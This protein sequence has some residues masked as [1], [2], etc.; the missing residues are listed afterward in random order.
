MYCGQLAQTVQPNAKCAGCLH[1]NKDRG[2][3]GVCEI[4]TRPAVCGDGNSPVIGYAPV[5]RLTPEYPIVMAPV[6]QARSKDAPLFVV[7]VQ[8]LGEEHAQMVKSIEHELVSQVQSRCSLHQQMSKGGNG[9][10]SVHTPSHLMSCSCTPVSSSVIAKSVMSRLSNAASVFFAPV[11]IAVFVDDI[12]KGQSPLAAGNAMLYWNDFAARHND[13]EYHAIAAKSAVVNGIIA[14]KSGDR[15]KL[16]DSLHVASKN[17]QHCVKSGHQS[18]TANTARENFGLLCKAAGEPDTSDEWE[19]ARLHK[20]QAPIIEIGPN[21]G[22]IIARTKDNKPIYAHEGLAQHLVRYA[23]HRSLH[24]Q[25]PTHPEGIGDAAAKQHIGEAT[26]AATQHAASHTDYKPEDHYQ[27]AKFHQERLRDYNTQAQRYYGHTDAHKQ[28]ERFAGRLYHEELMR[29]HARAAKEG[30]FDIAAHEKA[31]EEAENKKLL[32]DAQKIEERSKVEKFVYSKMP[33]DRRRGMKEG[34]PEIWVGGFRST[35]IGEVPAEKLMELARNNGWTGGTLPGVAPLTDVS[36]IGERSGP[37]WGWSDF[38][39]KSTPEVAEYADK[40]V[41][42][43][44]AGKAKEREAKVADQSQGTFTGGPHDLHA[45]ISENK[46]L[47]RLQIKFSGGRVPKEVYNS[48]KAR[49]FKWAPSQDAFQRQLTDNARSSTA[50]LV[51]ELGLTK[52]QDAEA[53]E[54]PKDAP[55]G[56]DK[57]ESYVDKLT[58]EHAEKEAKIAE[59]VASHTTPEK[60]ADWMKQADEGIRQGKYTKEKVE[61]QLEGLR[62]KVA[63][64]PSMSDADKVKTLAAIKTWDHILKN[65]K[66]FNKPTTPASSHWLKD[67]PQEKQEAVHG[68][69]RAIEDEYARHH[70]KELALRPQQGTTGVGNADMEHFFP[71]VSRASF[72]RAIRNGKTPDEA[73]EIAKQDVKE[74]VTKWNENGQKGRAT[75]G[76]TRASLHFHTGTEDSAILSMQH[77]FRDALA[78]QPKKEGEG[79]RGGKV[80]GHRKDGSP[81]YDSEI[82]RDALENFVWKKT[83]ED[84]RSRGS[85][86]MSV[87]TGKAKHESLAHMPLSDLIAQAKKHGWDG[88]DLDAKEAPKPKKNHNLHDRYMADWRRASDSKLARMLMK[89]EENTKLAKQGINPDTGE[90]DRY[91]DNDYKDRVAGW[92]SQQDANMEALRTELTRRGYKDTSDAKALHGEAL[93]KEKAGGSGDITL[94]DVAADTKKQDEEKAEQRKQGEASAR[95]DFITRDDWNRDAHEK[96]SGIHDKY[97]KEARNEKDKAYHESMRDQHKDALSAFENEDAKGY[98]GKVTELTDRILGLKTISEVNQFESELSGLEEAHK[99]TPR[100]RKLFDTH[101]KPLYDTLDDRRSVINKEGGDADVFADI[102][103]DSAQKPGDLDA[104]KKKADQAAKDHEWSEKDKKSF[105]KQYDELLRDLEEEEPIEDRV[106]RKGV[107]PSALHT[108][109]KIAGKGNRDESPWGTEDDDAERDDAER[110]LVAAGYVK[111]EEGEPN[112]AGYTTTILTLTGKGKAKLAEH[113]G[114]GGLSLTGTAKWTGPV[115]VIAKDK[116]KVEPKKP[117]EPKGEHP[118]ITEAKKRGWK[119]HPREKGL[120]IHPDNDLIAVDTDEDGTSEIMSKRKIA[121][122][123]A[124]YEPSRNS[125][126]G[127]HDVVFAQAE[128]RINYWKEKNAKDTE[129]TTHKLPDGGSV[130]V[131]PELLEA[132]KDYRQGF[133]KPRVS[134]GNRS[135]ENQKE[136]KHAETAVE[137]AIK[138]LMKEHEGLSGEEHEKR[139][140]ALYGLVNSIGTDKGKPSDAKSKLRNDQGWALAHLADA[141]AREALKDEKR[142]PARD[143]MS[144]IATHTAAGESTLGERQHK[145]AEAFANAHVKKMNL[146]AKGHQAEA[147]KHTKLAQEGGSRARVIYHARLGDAHDRAIAALKEKDAADALPGKKHQALHD[148]YDL[149]EYKDFTPDMDS[150]HEERA[151]LDAVAGNIEDLRAKRVIPGTFVEGAS[152]L[153][154]T[155]KEVADHMQKYH[156]LRSAGLKRAEKARADRNAKAKAARDAE[157]TSYAGQIKGMSA[158]EHRASLERLTDDFHKPGTPEHQ[159]DRVQRKISAHREALAA[160]KDTKDKKTAPT[161]AKPPKATKPAVPKDGETGT[162]ST[163]VV[164]SKWNHLPIPA[165]NKAFGRTGLTNALVHHLWSE[166]HE[167]HNSDKSLEAYADRVIG[168]LWNSG[169]GGE[170]TT[171][172]GTALVRK[173]LSQ[174]KKIGVVDD[175]PTGK[176][177]KSEIPGLLFMPYR[178]REVR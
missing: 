38:K 118:H 133:N 99:D 55:K 5:D 172:A 20:S 95:R 109:G 115:P 106:K 36:K 112:V 51:K 143:L 26:N 69:M 58:R 25:N 16:R 53:A 62:K 4:G 92:Q 162:H 105:Q 111:E 52:Q 174:L 30:G 34:K 103:R 122:G 40:Y 178:L 120:Y 144:H 78:D 149:E 82:N 81:I 72:V 23:H 152:K 164:V 107:S 28:A 87:N 2:P 68:V 145:D 148:A 150:L 135:V 175:Y 125:F 113:Q 7:P 73:A 54:P 168:P 139:A 43:R 116:P 44:L 42:E 138:P 159:K 176:L 27:A 59:A 6:A 85:G 32:A 147:D 136:I 98:E 127:K 108:L 8:V 130:T 131:S 117:E 158:K 165:D 17:L 79:S 91:R 13:P 1:F 142:Y 19:P 161:V 11:E 90:A 171:E 110:E 41:N 56:D 57:A 160:L 14:H 66:E 39:G 124:T 80:V 169:E 74:A 31:A 104:W 65:S 101:I 89:E 156:D 64:T 137:R 77:K 170:Y 24:T 134:Y 22:K 86:T 121:G 83:P 70:E 123:K 153:G 119:E 157:D 49:G 167:G 10:V 155:H 126:V 61:T 3:T 132:A 18:R 71:Q 48:L 84:D 88:E 60:L 166:F 63:D 9:F 140:A 97:A 129:G 50:A 141:H 100:E 102:M 94:G 46:G 154:L 12:R 37:V 67:L 15:K 76:G 173:M 163:G 21:G 128:N 177:A 75:F 96:Y 146:D 35:P 29:A 114:Q 93:K 33:N 151:H 47:D 45:E